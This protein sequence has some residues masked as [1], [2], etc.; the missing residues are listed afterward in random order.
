MLLLVNPWIY[1]FAA[2]DMYSAPLGLLYIG[3][4]LKHAGL[5]IKLVNCLDRFHPG[6]QELPYK[7]KPR[8]KKDGTG[9]FYRTFV[10]RPDIYSD[11]PRNYSRYGVPEEMIIKDL[12]ALEKPEAVFVTS[13]MTYWYNGVK[14]LIDTVKKIWP[15]VPVVL[16]GIY[17]SLLPEHA[18]NNTGADIVVKG[19]GEPQIKSLLEKL[20]IKTNLPNLYKNINDYPLPALE[21]QNKTNYIPLLTSRGC[22]YRCT[23]CASHKIAGR[24]RRRNINS[25][26]EEAVSHIEKFQTKTVVFFDDALLFE[27]EDHILPVLKGITGQVKNTVFHTPNGLNPREIDEK[28]AEAM[29]SAGFGMIRLSLETISPGRRKDISNKVS[30]RSFEN[31]VKNLN[32]AGY[33][34]S[35]LETYILMGLPGQTYGEVRDTMMFAND[36]GVK[37]RLA[38]YS[39]IPG[40]KD[41]DRAVKMGCLDPD[42]DILQTNNTVVPLKQENMSYNEVKKLR[43][44]A[45]KLNI[46][47]N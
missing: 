30:E 40:T 46:E 16:G 20:S 3:G 8:E 33:K 1:D 42:A 9:K 41:W 11:I 36:T 18:K 12:L 10:D 39:P 37:I 45:G 34:R 23:F 47:L 19:E 31:A 13:H 22:P 7:Q 6:L 26:V 29:Y 35:S 25:V 15:D 32:N 14:Y 24:F 5:D 21:I 2:Y 17:A 44:L 38:S 43:E 27:K 28:T 4:V